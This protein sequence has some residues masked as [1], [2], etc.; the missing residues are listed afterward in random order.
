MDKMAEPLCTVVTG[1][2]KITW[3]A[4]LRLSMVYSGNVNSPQGAMRPT[5][6]GTPFFWFLKFVANDGLQLTFHFNPRLS[7][8]YHTFHG[9]YDPNDA[10]YGQFFP[11]Q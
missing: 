2:C 9:R 8:L 10:G 4:I 3:I 7:L 1:C 6:N 5:L 11:S